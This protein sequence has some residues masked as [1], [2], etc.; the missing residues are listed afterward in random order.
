M[1]FF[2]GLVSIITLVVVWLLALEAALDEPVKLV[3][4]T[5]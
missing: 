1:G 5:I 3:K 4:K 2:F